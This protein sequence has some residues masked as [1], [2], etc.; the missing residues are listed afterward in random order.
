MPELSGLI[1][2]NDPILER[3]PPGTRVYCVGGAVRDMLLGQADKDRD[4]VVVGADVEAMTRAG[5]QPVGKDF[6]VF[7][8]PV[9]HDEYALARTERKSGRGYK[10]FVFRADPSVT[11]EED[12][13]RRDLTINAIA[14]D[15]T[16]QI[17]DPFGGVRDLRS[18]CLR[19]VGP[20]F[21][22]DP[23]RLLRVARFTARWPDFRMAPETLTLCRDIVAA[24]E[25]RALVAERVWQEI[26]TGLMESTPSR[27]IATLVHTTA[28]PEIFACPA[29]LPQMLHWLDEAAQRQLPLECRYA[30][31]V[32]GLGPGDSAASGQA[33]ARAGQF[34]APRHCIELAM[35][36]LTRQADLER[37][38]TA[39]ARPS[40]T[41]CGDI[42]DWLIACDALRRPS[43]LEQL[44]VCLEVAGVVHPDHRRDLI[45]LAKEAGGEEAGQMA[46]AAAM[47]AQSRGEPV[48][49]AARAARL[50]VLCRHPRLFSAGS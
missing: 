10:G 40:P 25:M 48:G 22:E 36:L 19:H 50:V 27:M 47:H 14:V 9:S 44:L 6:P 4:F 1:P 38:L 21:S 3:L 5:F 32:L 20:A 17:I 12:L 35:A 46:A 45:L 43:R 28:W 16:G 24:G 31:L 26:S 39:L 2:D 34:K 11:L 30:L 37:V 13:S 7:L 42:L 23:L 41:G 18:R 8:H 49:P 33:P 29:P 15:R